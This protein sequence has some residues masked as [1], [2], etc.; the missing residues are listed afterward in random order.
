MR[1]STSIIHGTDQSPWIAMNEPMPTAPT[2]TIH[3][4]RGSENTRRTPSHWLANDGGFATRG[5]SGT[6]HAIAAA[7]ASVT[8]PNT[9]N[10]VR[11]PMKRSANSTGS[12][13]ASA[14][15]PPATMIQPE[16]DACRCGEYQ[17]AMP[18]RGAIRHTETPSPISARAIVRPVSPSAAANANA[19]VAAI[20]SSTGS[21]RR[22][23]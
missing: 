19:P 14:P 11:Q 20:T 21:T 10:S 3:Q 17:T 2:G 18:F 12:V 23:P 5:R 7:T 16:S 22:G 4:K 8:T 15:T 1:P 13:A 6:R 9:T